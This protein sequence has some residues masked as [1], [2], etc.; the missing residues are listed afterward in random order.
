MIVNKEKIKVAV[1]DII[2]VIVS[3]LYTIGIRAWFPVCEPMEDG[4]FMACHWAGEVLKAIS[5]LLLVLACAHAFCA[6]DGK[7]K[8]GLDYGIAGISALGFC[9][10]GRV[11]SLCKM[12]E[13][14]CR[15][16]T[17]LWTIIF[18]IAMILIAI[19]DVVL[20]FTK[21][22]DEKHARPSSGR[23]EKE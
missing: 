23:G 19:A 16:N 6:P 3:V 21:A 20:Y 7:I 1:T 18:M 22:S 5:I 15:A 10:P 8:T 14:R 12:A 9:I 4:S 2:M 17:Q 11:I 13:M